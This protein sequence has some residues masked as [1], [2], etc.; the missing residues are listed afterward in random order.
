V[1]VHSPEDNGTRLRV[2]RQINEEQAATVR[3]VF[4]LYAA[5]IGMTTIAHRRNQDGVKPPRGRGWAPSGIREMLHRELYRGMVVWNRSQK[6]VRAGTKKQRRRD[7]SAWI[8]IGAP[9][10]R[11]I[12]DDLWQRVKATLD[13]RAAIFPHGSD[14]KLMGRPRY[15]DEPSY[16]LV[17]FARCSTCG[18]PVGTD[19][20][21]WG[22]A[23][24]RRS[25]PH[26]AC[27]DSKRRGRAICINRVALRQDL[28]DRAILA[29]IGDALDPTVL[30]GAVEK[31]LARLAKQQ[32]AHI[33]RRAVIERELAQ[34]QQR[35]DRLIDA[36]ADGSLPADEIK[37]RLSTEKARKTALTTDLTRFERLAKV[38][39]VQVDQIADR[40]CARISDVGGLLGRRPRK[41]G[42][43]FGRS[44]LTRSSSSQ[45]DQAGSAAT[46]S[47]VP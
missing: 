38:G 33:E 21:G 32:R 12:S 31:A 37:T 42:K 18:G 41:L 26:Y 17:G 45:S 30:S 7:E 13:A 40:L 3:R 44:S 9:D 28:L 36:L 46:S 19:L 24:A 5:G 25:V 23:G 29:A 11:I 43:C 2:V 6:I 47:G 1:D 22:P 15:K 16:L 35:L 8:R 27:L 20:R 10:L 14:R 4:E 39:T 34:V